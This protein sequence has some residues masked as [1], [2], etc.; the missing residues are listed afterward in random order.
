ME[1]IG[2][3][4]TMFINCNMGLDGGFHLEYNFIISAYMIFS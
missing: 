3:I 1:K 2:K 4:L